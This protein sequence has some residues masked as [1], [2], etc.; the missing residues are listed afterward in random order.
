M[1]KNLRSSELPTPS[2]KGCHK[3]FAGE[4]PVA[5]NPINLA[6]QSV[7]RQGHGTLS[8]RLALVQAKKYLMCA[9]LL[10]LSVDM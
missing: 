8:C 5:E 4:F 10:M 2:F 3:N 1:E 7:Y 6:L 9:E